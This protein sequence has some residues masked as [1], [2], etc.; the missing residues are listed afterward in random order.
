MAAQRGPT[1]SASEETVAVD[2]RDAP[3]APAGVPPPLPAIGGDK[4]AEPPAETSAETTAGTN[5]GA[6]LG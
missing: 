5:T 1:S 3:D 2:A 4:L 6:T